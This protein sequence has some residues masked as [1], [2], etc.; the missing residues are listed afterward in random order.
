MNGIYSLAFDNVIQKNNWTTDKKIDILKICLGAGVDINRIKSQ[1]KFNAIRYDN[2]E[3]I[4]FLI[5]SGINIRSDD[6]RALIYACEKNRK[7]IIELLLSLGSDAAAQNNEPILKIC[8]HYSKKKKI[9]IDMDIIKLLVTH[10]ANPF[11]HSNKLLQ[12]ACELENLELVK[13][14]ISIG[15]NCAE[16]DNIPISIAFSRKENYELKKLLLDNG[17]SP[18]II[19]DTRT[20]VTNNHTASYLCNLL[21]RSVIHFDIESCKLLITYGADINLCHNLTN[22][23]NKLRRYIYHGDINYGEEIKKI[24]DLFMEY[25]LDISWILENSESSEEED[26]HD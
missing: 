7:Q 24:V 1:A 17:A 18:N 3:N 20:H 5:D 10:G 13:Y 22:R 11:F 4:N 25:G 8:N 23:D 9:N 21:E 26:D 2:L 19:N 6:D 16:P 14:L 12:K 15:A